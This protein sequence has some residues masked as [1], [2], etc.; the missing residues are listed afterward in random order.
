MRPT[1]ILPSLLAL[2][3]SACMADVGGDNCVGE[4]CH[5]DMTD[6]GTTSPD[7][8]DVTEIKTAL[9]IA[10]DAD[11]ANV[12]KGCWSLNA[13]LRIQGSA[14]SSLAK[15][16]D[17]VDVNDLELVDTGLTSIDSKQH[18]KVYGNLLVSGNT[19]LAALQHLDVMKWDGATTGG[20][21]TV[22]YNVRNNPLLANIDAL[23]YIK[24][25]DGDLRFTDDPKLGM[26][27]LDELTK[28][29]GAVV[30]TNTGAPMVHLT[31]LTQVGRVEIGMNPALTEVHGFGA[32][33][34][35]GDVILRGNPVL[36]QIGAMS[37]LSTIGG[38]L[39]VDDNDALTDLAGLTGAMRSVYGSVT[40]SNNANLTGLGQL[41]H[42]S[43]IGTTSITS[44]PKL[45]YCRAL[46]V[47]R[48]VPNSTVTISGNLNQNNC[49]S[50][51]GL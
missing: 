19:K 20:T 42:L 17:L 4:R 9:T 12:P 1:T 23:K 49:Q 7:C 36:S 2:T 31:A 15:L 3:A 48:C 39:T 13:T 37:S 41:S 34:I 33:S 27:E 24:T 28:V 40:I 6:A 11:F 32:T 8:T 16:G 51:C 47:D 29:G 14:I 30:I 22:T 38:A 21:W 5:D 43:S 45:G 18:I 50:W 35:A 44:N 25:V 26:I 46:E 10:S